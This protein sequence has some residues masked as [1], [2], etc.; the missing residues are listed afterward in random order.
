MEQS[1]T[2]DY[3]LRYLNIYGVSKLAMS[4]VLRQKSAL[5]EKIVSSRSSREQRWSKLSIYF[6]PKYNEN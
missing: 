5:L 3:L 4:A 6:Y 2:T 1:E